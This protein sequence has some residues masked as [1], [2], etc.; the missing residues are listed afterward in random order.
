M[1][2]S[3]SFALRSALT[4]SP[5]AWI[6][7][8]A[9]AWF[10]AQ[11]DEAGRRR[12]EHLEQGADTHH[13]PERCDEQAW[14]ESAYVLDVLR[15]YAPAELPDGHALDV[16]SKNGCYAPG[17]YAARAVPWTLVEVDA[18]RRYWW[19]S[20]RRAHGEA[21]VRGL[22]GSTFVA[23]DV[24]ALTGRFT[25][26][27]WFLPFLTAVPLEAWGLPAALLQ[28]RALL[29]HVLGLV[30]PGGALLIVNQGEQ[31]AALQAQLLDGLGVHS[32]AL[33]AVT[34]ALSPF[35][36]PRFGFLVRT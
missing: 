9:K 8:R 13:W 24:R 2:H 20:T 31:E 25:L 30:V 7:P 19:G 12:F 36:K 10:L 18:H 23:G 32:T 4:W 1:R 34:S 6:R 17:L 3:W 27:T 35:K 5:P 33:G 26:V 14:R 22:G 11:L 21:M 16:G 28:P 15:R 29:E